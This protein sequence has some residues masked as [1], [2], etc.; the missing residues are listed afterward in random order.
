VTIAAW[1][2]PQRP[3]EKFGWILGRRNPFVT[4]AFS[5]EINNEGLLATTLQTNVPS[6]I[7][8]AVPVIPFNGQWQHVAM[9]ADTDTGQVHLYVNG[10]AVPLQVLGGSETVSGTFA[11]VNHIFIG[12]RQSSKTPERALGAAHFKGLIADLEVY[13]RALSPGEIQTIVS[14]SHRTTRQITT[15]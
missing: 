14:A 9:T 12:Q 1:I 2:N 11:D 6:Y 10:Q 3:P 5:L 4:E 8:S 15:R 7:A 13:N